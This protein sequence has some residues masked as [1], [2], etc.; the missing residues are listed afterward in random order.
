[1]SFCNRVV[2]KP[3]FLNNSNIYPRIDNSPISIKQGL[4]LPGFLFA[5]WFN[6]PLLAAGF[7]IAH[8]APAGNQGGNTGKPDRR[9][10]GRLNAGSDR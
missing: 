4:I 7:V 10:P 6:T 3:Q 8:Y 9:K 5:S 2:R 1:M